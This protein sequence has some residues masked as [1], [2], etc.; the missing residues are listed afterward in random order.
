M[1]ARERSEGDEGSEREREGRDRV[2]ERERE[3][4]RDIDIPGSSIIAY[5]L[6]MSGTHMKLVS[7]NALDVFLEQ[8]I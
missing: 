1:R 4:E 8:I 3:R 6:L 2:R 5:G 7:I